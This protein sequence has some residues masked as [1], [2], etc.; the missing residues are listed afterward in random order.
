MSLTAFSPAVR[1]WL[2]AWFDAPT[3]AQSMGCKGI[4]NG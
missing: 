3:P 1:D 4:A 2:V